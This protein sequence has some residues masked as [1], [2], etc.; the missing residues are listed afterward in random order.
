MALTRCG[1]M[2]MLLLGAAAFGPASL[3]VDGFDCSWIWRDDCTRSDDAAIA[4]RKANPDGPC[5]TP[6]GDEPARCPLS[7]EFSIEAPTGKK[8]QVTFAQ[9]G[10]HKFSVSLAETAAF[11]GTL[12]YLGNSARLSWTWKGKALWCSGPCPDGPFV[13]QEGSKISRVGSSA[14]GTAAVT[15]PASRPGNLRGAPRQ[16]MTF[17]TS[18]EPACTASWS[19]N[20]MGTK[21]CC[22]EGFTC[23][24]KTP[25]WA[26]C[27]QSCTPGEVQPG[28]DG[29]QLPWTCKKLSPDAAG[30]LRLF[31]D[32]ARPLPPQPPH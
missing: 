29:K 1:M 2:A 31:L 17:L 28:D 21:R 11:N 20:C 30:W 15:K 24:E 6:G 13:C 5:H 32:L 22:D 14:S 7:G 26:A 27:L 12:D 9:I 3:N 25:N 18:E 19:E 8:R 10:N 16:T 23:Y 4:C